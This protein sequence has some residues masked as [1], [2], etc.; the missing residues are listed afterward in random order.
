MPREELGPDDE[1]ATEEEACDKG[2]HISDLDE[3]TKRFLSTFSTIR[4][5]VD[6]VARAESDIKRFELSIEAERKR[7]Q[8]NLDSAKLGLRQARIQMAVELAKVDAPGFGAVA[9]VVK[10]GNG[11]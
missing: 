5:K 8:K 9:E 2:D 11:A 7:L 3:H 6:D 10:E 1:L 4:S